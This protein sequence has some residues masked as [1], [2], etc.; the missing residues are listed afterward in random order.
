[1]ILLHGDNTFQQNWFYW[2]DITLFSPQNKGGHILEMDLYLRLLL[3][4]V[5]VGVATAIKRTVLAL[6]FGKKT[7]LYYKPRM[8]K[9]RGDM[10]IISDVAQ[11]GSEAEDLV[12]AASDNQESIGAAVTKNM[13]RSVSS[14]QWQNIADMEKLTEGESHPESLGATPDNVKED[15]GVLEPASDN[16]EPVEDESLTDSYEAD[17]DDHQSGYDSSSDDD[18][19]TSHPAAEAGQ[20]KAEQNLSSRVSLTGSERAFENQLD[21]WEEPE[22]KSDKVNQFLTEGDHN[23]NLS[24]ILFILP[25]MVS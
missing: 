5:L 17:D 21:R 20:H 1:M 24:D 18:S 2:T 4:M 13:S 22:N 8:D 6:F 9:L 23:L 11:L 3:V 12:A 7:V 19:S 16:I 15:P 14:T 10:L 25:N